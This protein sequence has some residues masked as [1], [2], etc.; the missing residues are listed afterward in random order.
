MSQLNINGYTLN[1]NCGG[2]DALTQSAQCSWQPSASASPSCCTS[3]PGPSSSSA[4]RQVSRQA[5][6]MRYDHSLCPTS[7]NANLSKLLDIL[8][9][10]ET[11]IFAFLDFP[12]L[13]QEIFRRMEY[14]MQK[15][16][17]SSYSLV[18]CIKYCC[19]SCLKIDVTCGQFKFRFW[20]AKTAN[21]DF[22]WEPQWLEWEQ[23]KG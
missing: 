11:K 15:N 5:S 4:S 14:R 9:F 19:C 17:V 3:S 16:W 20:F 21:I 12:F 22:Y 23:Q 10:K 18:L 6:L 1:F 13:T 2:T 8:M 7:I